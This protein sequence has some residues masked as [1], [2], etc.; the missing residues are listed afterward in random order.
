MLTHSVNTHKIRST[1]KAT[2]RLSAR[3]QFKNQLGIFF[4]NMRPGHYFYNYK[5][6]NN[7]IAQAANSI[8]K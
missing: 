5:N 6:N 2:K 8:A 4:S 1:L 7:K 3:G